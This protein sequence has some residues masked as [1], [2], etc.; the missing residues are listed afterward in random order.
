MSL[1]HPELIHE[2]PEPI[3]SLDLQTLV[4]YRL[5]SPGSEWRLHRD[6]FEKSAMGD[7]LGGDFAL[8]EIHKLYQCLDHLLTHNIS[9]HS[10]SHIASML[11]S[12]AGSAICPCASVPVLLSSR[13]GDTNGA[14]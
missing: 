7:L 10:L 14:R 5:I 13:T 2:N 4:S 12:A 1:V 6:W 8:V 9:C 3:R 11:S